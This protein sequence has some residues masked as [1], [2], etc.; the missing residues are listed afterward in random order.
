MRE[1]A[2]GVYVAE[3]YLGAN[4]GCVVMDEGAVLVDAPIVP[5]QA[6]DWRERVRAV[7][8]DPLLYVLLTDSHPNHALGSSQFDAPAVA[9]ERGYRPLDRFTP[10][11][12]ERVLDGFRDTAPEVVDE[13]ADM[14]VVPPQITFDRDLVFYLNGNTI[15]LQRL[16]GHSPASSAVLLEESGVLFAG[17]VIFNGIPPF[18]GHGHLGEWLQA[19]QVIRGWA[20]KVV[21]PGHGPAGDLA[22][23]DSME[24]FLLRLRAGVTDL[25]AEGRSRA[26]TATRMLHLL[27]E[28]EV[29]E[30]WRKRAERAFR[31]S[32][33]RVYEELKKSR[34]ADDSDRE[35]EE[36]E[37]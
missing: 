22:L 18:L 24:D 30:I 10:T 28:F 15:R 34:L 7:G 19:L 23:V 6:R 8:G 13:L 9:N 25:V 29:D 11:M 31:T 4:V 3:D 21:V 14:E 36:T 17:D 1:I 20:P 16:G 35:A 12:R 2:T 27:D 5:S 32:V 26:E 37:E 33:G